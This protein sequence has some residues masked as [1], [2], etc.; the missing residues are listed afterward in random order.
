MQVLSPCP[1]GVQEI[2]TRVHMGSEVVRLVRGLNKNWATELQTA[3]LSL[4]SLD[5]AVSVNLGVRFLGALTMRGL[6]SWG[7]Y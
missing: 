5:I 3:H 1:L 4:S 7:L 2:M 6:L